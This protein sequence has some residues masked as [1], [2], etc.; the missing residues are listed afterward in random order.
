MGTRHQL[1]DLLVSILGSKNVY[2]QPPP[3]F[4]MNY[5]CIVYGR[6]SIKSVFA[7]NSLYMFKVRYRVTYIDADP[8]SSVPA[9]ILEL[10][11]CSFDRHF[12]TSN[13][14]HDVFTIYF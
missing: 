6:E 14:N 9:L 10:P 8:D 4:Q 3:G 11:L 7:N 1:Q 2:F 13:L 5:P 12:K